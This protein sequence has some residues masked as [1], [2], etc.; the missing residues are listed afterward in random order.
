MRKK[1]KPFSRHQRDE[2]SKH[3]QVTSPLS[4]NHAATPNL[5]WMEPKIPI[6]LL[7]PF[8]ELY[9]LHVFSFWLFQLQTQKSPCQRLS[10]AQKALLPD[11]CLLNSVASLC[12]LESYLLPSASLTTLSNEVS[13]SF[14]WSQPLFP[15]KSA[16]LCPKNTLSSFLWST[17]SKIHTSVMRDLLIDYVLAD[18]H[19]CDTAPPP[20]PRPRGIS[21]QQQAY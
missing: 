4:Q 10:S 14:Q 17:F 15:M 13:L 12:L 2:I 1:F 7:A 8:S 18:W 20:A 21:S 16:C 6:G 3:N 9:N 11:I 5:L 19:L